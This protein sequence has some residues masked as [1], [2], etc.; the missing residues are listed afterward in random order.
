VTMQHYLSET[1]KIV[2]ELYVSIY[3]A[4]F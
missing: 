4:E 3:N 2:M 1:Y